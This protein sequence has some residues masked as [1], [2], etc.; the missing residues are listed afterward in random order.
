MVLHFDVGRAKSV[1]ASKGHARG[2]DDLPRNTEGHQGRRRAGRPLPIGTVSKVRQMFKLPAENVRLIEGC[3][4]EACFDGRSRGYFTADVGDPDTE[5]E[6]SPKREALIRGSEGLRRTLEVAP[7]MTHEVMMNVVSATE[8]GYRR[9]IAQNIPIKH[10]E[11]RKYS[12][13]RQ[14]KRL[15]GLRD[16]LPRDRAARTGGDISPKSASDSQAP[17]RLLPSRAAPPSRANSASQRTAKRNGTVYK[18]Y[19]GT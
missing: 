19:T 14:D 8:T 9:Y 11:N 16:P 7:R 1:K 15:E 4:G 6:R 17:A 5:S 10:T 12:R 3:T 18:R 13:S 2:P